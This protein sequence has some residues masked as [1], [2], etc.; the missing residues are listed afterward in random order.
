V[1]NAELERSVRD[2]LNRD[3]RIDS[4]GIAVSANDGTVVLRG[5]THTLREKIEARRAAQRVVGVAKVEDHLEPRILVRRADNELRGAVLQA[6]MLDSLVPA[7]VDVEAFDGVV[8]LK[9]TAD[10][11]FQRDEAF[12]VASRV[13][14][15]V[16][17]IDE[18]T[19][20]L[21]TPDAFDVEDGITRAF[22]RNAKL[23]AEDLAV[24]SADGTVTISG[25]VSSWAERDEAV[26]AALA[27]P[28]VQRVV[29]EIVVAC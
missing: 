29:D 7:T 3:S 21:S 2:E 18:I 9:G 8:T 11:R 15:V 16:D 26:A 25:T 4:P 23:H 5:T 13:K 1:T 28:G 19:L 17:V 24:R 22:E 27:S 12:D 14:G 10:R 20:P 6:L